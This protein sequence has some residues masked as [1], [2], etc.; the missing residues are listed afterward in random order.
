MVKRGEAEVVFEKE[1][2]AIVATPGV[3]MNETVA[4]PRF[5]LTTSGGKK[6]PSDVIAWQGEWELIGF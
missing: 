4:T 6:S 3:L 5:K 2:E 1:K